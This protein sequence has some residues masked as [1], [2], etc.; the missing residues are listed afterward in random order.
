MN[1]YTHMVNMIIHG[2]LKLNKKDKENE[3][4]KPNWEEP[5]KKIKKERKKLPFLG[6]SFDLETRF[7]VYPQI[8]RT[9]TRGLKFHSMDRWTELC[10]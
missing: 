7:L 10:L 8:S 9:W 2:N 3:K 4:R 5:K 6:F 1:S